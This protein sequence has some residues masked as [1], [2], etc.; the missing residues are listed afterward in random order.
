MKIIKNNG[1]L[2]ADK[3]I[4]ELRKVVKDQRGELYVAAYRNGR[5]SGYFVS[6]VFYGRKTTMP[7][8]REVAVTEDRRSD[9]IVVYPVTN[10]GLDTITDN[11]YENRTMFGQG[12]YNKTAKF[13]AK[14][15]LK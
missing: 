9:N 2:V 13:I 15:L 3:V 5:E 14:L 7:K 10:I 6:T 8:V 1:L 11:A 4:A 12:E